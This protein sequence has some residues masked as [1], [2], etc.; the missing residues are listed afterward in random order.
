MLERNKERTANS[1]LWSAIE[2]F[3]VQGIQFILS[4]I[5]ARLVSP[6]DYGLIAMLGIF[7]AVA[8]TFIDSGFSS[9]LIQKHKCTEL[10]FSTVFYFS[11]IVS[12]L[13]YCLIYLF[14]PCIAV[15][16]HET[17]L[18]LITRVVG[19][20]LI[21]NSL[22][23][24]QR[25][26]LTIDLNFKLQAIIAF[27]AVVISGIAGVYLAYQKWGVWALVFQT[28]LYNILSTFL[29]IVFAKWKPLFNFSFRSFK[30]L[31]SFG[32]K[33]LVG[34][35][36]H[37]LYVNLY[38]LVIG[39]YFSA[40][41]LGYFNRANSISQYPS[42]NLTNIISRVT[43]PIECKIQENEELLQEKFFLF[44]RMAT[45]IIF[46]LMIGLCA[47]AEP[48]VKLLLTD[49]W[50]PAVPF[51]QI[52]C[53]AYMWDPVQ[54]MCWELLNV[55]HRS[56]Y[57]LKSEIIKK[58]IAF[59]ILLLTIWGGIT[60]MCWGL[61]LYAF[62]DVFIITKFTIKVLDKVTYKN[63]IKTIFPNLLLSVV[64][65]G[66]VSLLSLLWSNVW[67]QLFF[68]TLLGGLF[69]LGFSYLFGYREI[70]LLIKSYFNK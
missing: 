14:S 63:V 67:L 44:L 9:A 64:M 61:V 4:I 28:L 59:C 65:G 62:L 19:L 55:K 69:Y 36:L 18:I 33:L 54:R 12:I 68:G 8:Q 40:T 57:S 38:T 50:L 3:S 21:I 58:I 70:K 25:A 53:V 10:D 47:L 27:V 6:S 13:V 48:L 22:A 31:F 42:F 29:F 23:T 7:L 2:R 37:S 5:I 46:P 41:E 35:L 16:Y 15:F 1:M 56:D 52:M 26:K 20:N 60:I 66:I 34:G 11:I 45:Y 39:R 30:V 24:V 32:S 49:K 51:L 43:Y 17:E